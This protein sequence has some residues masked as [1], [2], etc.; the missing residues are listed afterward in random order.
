ME[1]TLLALSGVG[2]VALE[3]NGIGLKILGEWAGWFKV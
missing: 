1:L 2:T 3:Y